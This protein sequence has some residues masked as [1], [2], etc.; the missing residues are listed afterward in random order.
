MG[1]IIL[2]IIIVYLTLLIV[3]MRIAF[4]AKDNKRLLAIFFILVLVLVPTWDMPF[5]RY[6]FNQLCEKE[7]GIFVY[8]QVGLPTEFF[9]A[10]GELTKKTIYHRD[11]AISVRELGAIGYELNSKKIKERFT[12]RNRTEQ[13][14]VSWGVVS[15]N[16]TAVFDGDQLLGKA[17]SIRGG[18]GWFLEKFNLGPGRP[19]ITCPKALSK[20]DY[21]TIHEKL[22]YKVFYKLV[23]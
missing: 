9:L 22:I 6:R 21:A 3:L 5:D 18:A 13:N 4:R 20:P 7:G 14:V 23:N 15:K 19:G 17:V 8:H 16:T 2:G 1:L 11:G 10:P 12:I